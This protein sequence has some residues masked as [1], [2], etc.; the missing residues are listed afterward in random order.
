MSVA[1]DPVT[2]ATVYTARLNQK[3]VF[4]STDGGAHWTAS[5]EGIT[6][7]FV[8]ALAVDPRT[9]TT[10]YAGT[11][12]FD[13][14][15]VFKS[16][17]GGI[18]WNPSNAGFPPVLDNI[19]SAITTLVVDPQSPATLYAGTTVGVFKSTDAGAS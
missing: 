15:G 8:T 10:V 1:I 17:D 12:G 7:V 14:W 9:P 13:V 3:A 4:K 6:A 19:S 11:S 18:H 16:V 2:P 5:D